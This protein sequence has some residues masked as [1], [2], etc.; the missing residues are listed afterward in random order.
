VPVLLIS[1]ATCRPVETDSEFAHLVD[2]GLAAPFCGWD[3][4]WLDTRTTRSPEA[5]DLQKRYDS[6][7]AALIAQSE[8]VLYLGTGDGERFA[9]YAPFPTA[10][11]ATEAHPPNVAAARS[12]L[13]PLGVEV[14]QTDPNCH[15]AR[16]PQPG[17]RW[18]RRRLPFADETFD[19]V[20][21]HRAAF[22]QAEGVRVL[23]HGGSLLTLQGVA[24][25]R[26]ET[27]ADALGGTPPDWTLPGFGWDVVE[28]FRHSGLRIIDWT[29]TSATIV[30]HDIGAIVYLLLHVPWHVVDFEVDRYRE[31]LYQ[32]H[33]RM[34]LQGDFHMR[35]ASRLIE[36]R[37]P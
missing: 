24:E 6:R 9:S 25:W 18:P 15:N 30:Y 20:L 3:L 14:V 28:S 23:R 31:R 4:S 16:G 8:A 13:M 22:S 33:R 34:Q 35:G 1:E 2:E 32:L 17:N 37:K 7:A 5:T 36:A 21:A 10:T 12:R 27:L 19:V 11:F 26:G 29:E